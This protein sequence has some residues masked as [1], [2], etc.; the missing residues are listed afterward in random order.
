MVLLSC[1]VL[2]H[3]ALTLYL[4]CMLL[5]VNIVGDFDAEQLEELC[6]K[7]LGTVAPRPQ[8]GFPED[9]PVVFCDPDAEMRRQTW[10]LRDSDERGCAY[11]A[12]PAPCR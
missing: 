8:A 10:H 2:S 5:Q 9:R 7:Y 12:G 3:T 6:L 1:A 4:G 11:I